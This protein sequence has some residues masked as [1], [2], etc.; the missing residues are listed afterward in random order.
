MVQFGYKLMA[1][2]H[3]PGALVANA[4]RAEELGFDFVAISDH[5]HPWLD[6]QRHASFAWSVLGGVAATTERI[7]IATGVTCPFLRYHPAIVAQAAATV[8]VLSGG[9]FTLQL[10]SGERLNEHVVG[11]GWP[12]VSVRH[13]ML[14]EAIDIIRL[15]WQG[16]MRSYRGRHLT[17]EDAQVFDLPDP[18]PQIVVAISGESSAR[19]AAEKGDGIVATDPLPELP[20]H[21]EQAGGTGP[22]YAEAALCWAADEA[23]AVKTAHER[24]RFGVPGWKVMAELPNPV[25][26]EAAT[27]T[28]RPEDVAASVACGPDPDR[29]VEVVKSYVDAGFDR[30]VLV[31]VGDDQEG[32]FRFWADELSSRLQA[33]R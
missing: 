11:R 23:E 27:A 33:L 32:F 13:E 28:V 7:G 22:R 1:E 18:L 2:E 9:R 25:N 15:L 16:G 10:G 3:G 29:H 20:R 5:Y 19:L 31:A 14:S 8:G 6:S 17:L 24:F 12:P 26:F 21:Y 30:V 4:R